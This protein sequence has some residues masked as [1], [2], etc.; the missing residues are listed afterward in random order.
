MHM[1]PTSIYDPLMSFFSKEAYSMPHPYVLSFVKD[2]EL[3]EESVSE[4][5]VLRLSHEQLTF[6]NLAPELREAVQ[7]LFR[8][9]AT[10]QQLVHLVLKMGG[11]TKLGQ[12]YNLLQILTDRC[13]LQYTVL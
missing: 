6:Q 12:L 13:L 10:E 9:G 4:C 5:I 3:S 8:S 11:T 2:V 7:L 1:T